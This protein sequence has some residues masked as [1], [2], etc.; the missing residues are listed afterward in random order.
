MR[1]LLVL[2]LL[3]SACEPPEPAPEDIDDLMAFAFRHYELADANQARSLADAG[4]NLLAWF[5]G[6]EWIEEGED[7]EEARAAGFSGTVANLTERA[8][9]ALDPPAATANHETAI[10]VLVARQQNCTLED[11][12]RI[13]VNPDQGTLFPDN[14]ISYSRDQFEDLDC[15]EAGDC[16]VA[17]WR[18]DIEQSQLIYTYTMEMASG[19]RRFEAVP[20]SD[21]AA[22]PVVARLSRTWMLDEPVLTPQDDVRFIQNYQ[23]EFMVP[24]GAGL[25]H[26][27]GQWIELEAPGINTGAP[28]FLN[29]YVDGLLEYLD[30]MGGLCQLE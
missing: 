20:A 2:T 15:Y 26:F 8:L 1:I 29:S 21:D 14:Y 10:G 3:L 7:V 4:V 28:I 12:D 27:Y 19:I 16:G 6:E 9:D 23:L 17:N 5:E 13:Y 24:N 22:D 25:V 11:I 18:A 30:V